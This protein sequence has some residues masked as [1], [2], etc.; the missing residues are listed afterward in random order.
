MKRS[1]IV[2]LTLM[3]A[4]IAVSVTAGNQLISP[5]QKKVNKP[6]NLNIENVLFTYDQGKLLAGWFI[7]AKNSR[8]T[9]LLMHGVRSNRG[10]MLGRAKMMIENG[11]SVFLFDFQAHGESEG[12]IIT[13]GFLESRDVESALNVLRQKVGKESIGVIG[14]SLGGASLL[15]SKVKNEVDVIVLEMVYS[16]LEQAVKNRLNIYLPLIGEYLS[17]LLLWQLEPRLGISTESLSPINQINKTNVP[18]LL[19]A[20]SDD[21]HTTMKESLAMYNNANEPKLL[22]VFEGA[23]HQDLFQFDKKKYTDTVLCFIDEH[24]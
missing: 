16:D 18:L 9:F 6:Q 1:L 14:V 24:L 20:G 5:E 12:E 23:H 15:L 11:Y 17:P 22:S 10:S 13:F 21:R 19:I 8:G 4:V 7:R 2:F 3:L